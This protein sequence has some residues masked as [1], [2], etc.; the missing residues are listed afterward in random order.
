MKHFIRF[1][2]VWCNECKLQRFLIWLNR[3]QLS[4]FFF[5]TKKGVRYVSFSVDVVAVGW[6]K[7]KKMKNIAS[8]SIELYISVMTNERNLYNCMLLHTHWLS[9]YYRMIIKS[10][11]QKY[12]RDPNR[13]FTNKL[14]FPTKCRMHVTYRVGI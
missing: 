6:Y 12:S 13:K 10:H 9:S 4:E 8:Y 3:A 11:I 1:I 2:V 14:I 7:W 5:Q